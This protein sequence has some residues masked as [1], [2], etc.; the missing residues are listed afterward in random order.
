MQLTKHLLQQTHD[1]CRSNRNLGL[2][3]ELLSDKLLEAWSAEWIWNLVAEHFPGAIQ[4]VDLYHARQ[5]LWEVGLPAVSAGQKGNEVY[6][7]CLSEGREEK[8]RAIR[9][10][11]EQRLKKDLGKLQAR[12]EKGQLQEEKK[13][14]Q[15]IGRL[16]ERYP[17]VA[18]YYPSSTTRSG[19]A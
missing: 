17:R 16:Q 2:Q 12:I 14:H 11:H 8:D 6:L 1:V 10:S 13:I 7:L 18:R 15:A 4:I 19:R 3:C 5:H 9:E